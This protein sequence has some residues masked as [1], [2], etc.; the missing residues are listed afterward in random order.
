MKPKDFTNIVKALKQKR[1][2]LMQTG[3]DIDRDILDEAANRHG[4]DIDLAEAD[5][6][7]EISIFLKSRTSDEIRH[8]DEALDRVV[9]GM[10]GSCDECG[11][12]IPKKRLEAL[13]Y[14][15][16]CVDCQQ[17]LEKASKEPE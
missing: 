15:I 12:E 2:Y 1:A 14:T 3:K 11:D 17:E 5:Y 9:K 16:Y 7:Q 6:E 4:D 13:P 8:I 10:Y